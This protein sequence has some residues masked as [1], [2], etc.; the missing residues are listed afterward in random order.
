[1]VSSEPR[2]PDGERARV[3]TAATARRGIISHRYPTVR[4]SQFETHTGRAGVS[5]GATTNPRWNLLLHL[6][7]LLVGPGS[8]SILVL[9]QPHLPYPRFC[10]AMRQSLI[11]FN[12]FCA[13]RALPTLRIRPSSSSFSRSSR[14]SPLLVY[15]SFLLL[16]FS[17][18][19]CLSLFHCCVS[20]IYFPTLVSSSRYKLTPHTAEPLSTADLWRRHARPAET[21]YSRLHFQRHARS[22]IRI[23]PPFLFWPSAVS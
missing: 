17:L 19:G 18:S 2:C 14:F 7:S 22:S 15:L 4:C 5:R 21:I 10:T 16:Y 20:A 9:R 6:P 13:A 12:N 1:M 11:K 23:F 3:S 8:R